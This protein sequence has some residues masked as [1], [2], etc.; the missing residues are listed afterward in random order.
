MKY[1]DSW[2]EL[3]LKNIADCNVEVLPEETDGDYQFHYVDISSVTQGNVE[4]DSNWMRFEDA[5][6]RA[7]RIAK[8]GDTIV[9]TVRTYLKAIAPV[10]NS[11]DP[12]VFSTGFAVLQ[13][14][15]KT[16]KRFLSYLLQSTTFI[17]EIMANSEGVSYPSITSGSLMALPTAIPKFA[18]QRRI[19]DYLDRETAHIDALI[20]RQ[21]QL[22]SLLQE[23]RPS[24]I[25]HLLGAELPNLDLRKVATIQSGITLSGEGSPE[26][27]EWPYLRVA[28]VQAGFIDTSEIKT[29]RI[30]DSE[31]RSALLQRGDVLMTEGGDI[32]KLGRGAIWDGAINPMLHQNH[33]YAVRPGPNL[34][35]QYLEYWLVS[36]VARD[37]FYSTAKKTTNLASTNK[38]TLGRLPIWAPPIEI[39]TKIVDK[40]NKTTKQIDALIAKT[41]QHIALARE[42]RAALITAAVTGQIEV[43]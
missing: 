43:P 27:S 8:P 5:P 29:I 22:I 23:R 16:S 24:A 37:Y 40:L 36:P 15:P 10:P 20:E 3:R 12:L 4:I 1:P 30:Q 21:T 6:S 17:D 38:T 35:P 18:E 39:Q 14:K 34:N 2:Q 42:R 19:A 33:I 13:P 26:L 32:D 9:S 28:N 11:N 25:G 7:R 41:E 31:A